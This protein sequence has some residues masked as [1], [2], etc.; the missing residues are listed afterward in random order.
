MWEE[1]FR[2]LDEH[3]HGLAV[4]IAGMGVSTFFVSLYFKWVHRIKRT[5]EKCV[6]IDNFVLPKLSTIGDSLLTL[7]TQF[8][9]LLVY[10]KSKDEKMD[11]STFRSRSPIQLTELGQRILIA[12]GGKEFIDTHVDELINDMNTYKVKT[13]LDAQIFAPIVVSDHTGHDSFNGIKNYIFNNPFY[14]EKNTADE[15]SSTALNL[16]AVSQI[17]GIYLRDKYLEKHPHLNPENA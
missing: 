1:L 14:K 12:V 13:A 11:L 16:S 6:K 17:M 3:Y 10:L 7:N 5:E 9:N 8:S 4:F 15:E 2:W